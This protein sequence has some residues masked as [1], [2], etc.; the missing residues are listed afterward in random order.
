MGPADGWVEG[1]PDGFEL[2]LID[3]IHVGTA[4]GSA[5]GSLDGALDGCPLGPP[6]GRSG[7]R[8]VVLLAGP[9]AAQTDSRTVNQ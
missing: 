7:S 2:R 9:M 6:V 5:E 4:T 1:S 8:W 3:G